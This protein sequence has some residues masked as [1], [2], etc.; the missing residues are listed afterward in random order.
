MSEPVLG[1]LSLDDLKE[2]L[3]QQELKLMRVK[4]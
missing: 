1:E 4:S 3:N 2:Q